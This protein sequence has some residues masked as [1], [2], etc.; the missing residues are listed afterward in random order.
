M[1][2]LIDLKKAK[3]SALKNKD[4]NANTV[5]GL[6]IASYQKQQVDKK[7]KGQEMT[8]ADMVSILNK[9]IKELTDEKKMF[10]E[11]GRAEQAKNDQIQIDILRAYLPEMMGEE[12]IREIIEALPDH[13][14][15]AIM[16]EFKSKYAS[17]VEMS[18]VSRIAKEYQ[19]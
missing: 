11:N 4:E 5:L 12:K 6:V 8:D 19:K 3:M 16:Q 9:T 7:A 17:Q 1:V 15:K 13:S 10:E 14:I 18:L 2:T